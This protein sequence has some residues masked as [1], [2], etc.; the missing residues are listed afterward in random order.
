MT[1]LALGMAAAQTQRKRHWREFVRDH[2]GPA[3]LIAL[4]A[5]M[6][7]G[8]WLALIVREIGG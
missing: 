6:L 4:A 8:S 2:A 7:I 5:G 1:R 3:L